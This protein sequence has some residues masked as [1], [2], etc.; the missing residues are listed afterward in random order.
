MVGK[1]LKIC[2][3]FIKIC[4]VLTFFSLKTVI[5]LAVSSLAI[6]ELLPLR[7][8]KGVEVDQVLRPQVQV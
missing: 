2:S 3:N 6:F 4:N 7:D 1:V 8:C 5:I